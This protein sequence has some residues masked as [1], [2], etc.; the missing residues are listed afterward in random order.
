MNED[1]HLNRPDLNDIVDIEDALLTGIKSR[2][3]DERSIRAIQIFDNQN[4]LFA[5]NEG[6]L[7]GRPDRPQSGHNAA[8]FRDRSEQTERRPEYPASTDQDGQSEQDARRARGG[9]Q[10]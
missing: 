5:V 6:V 10:W 8:E 3:I 2:S 1:F 4:A 9:T 7:A